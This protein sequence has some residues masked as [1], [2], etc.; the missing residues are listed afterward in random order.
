MIRGKAARPQ[1]AT[2]HAILQRTFAFVREE[3]LLLS[4]AGLTA[5]LRIPSLFEPLW[6]GDEA[7]YLTVGQ[8]LLR[9]DL[10]YV[11]IFDNKPPALYY[12]TAGSL[13]LFGHSVAAIKALP[14]IASIGTLFAFYYVARRLLD[15]PAALLGAA[16][17]SFLITPTWL[18]GNIVG[19]EILMILPTCIGML[20]GLQRRYFLAGCSFGL[21]F[22]FKVPAIFDFGAF[23]VFVALSVQKGSERRTL[24][25]LGLLATGL[26]TPF[27]LTVVY[28][29]AVG[30]LDEYFDS[31]FLSGVD[32]TSSE[33]ASSGGDFLFS[34]G[35][36]I[37]NG[38]PALLLVTVLAGRTFRRWPAGQPAAP[39]S[40][41][42]M[43]LWLAFSFYGVLLGGRPY[44]HYL[45]QAAPPFALLVA[46]V[47]TRSE[48]RRFLSAGALLIALAVTL[49]Q[50]FRVITL[51]QDFSLRQ[52]STLD[53]YID[54]N[55]NFVDYVFGDKEFDEYANYLDGHTAENYRVA[56]F[57]R[58]GSRGAEESLY[59]LSN[60]AAIYFQSRFYP[61]TRYVVFYHLEWDQARMEEAA[62]D[63]AEAPPLYLTA[64][65]PPAADFP[66]LEEI[67]RKDYRLVWSEGKLRLY[68]RR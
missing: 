40:F 1:R 20:L 43:L 5:L 51:D 39:D 21:A 4:I 23:F 54:Y 9:G 56:S 16:I 18:E 31:A 63:L 41:E 26:L 38:L 7:V 8:Q 68:K 55:R 67:I 14:L 12:L 24:S 10:L 46:F 27:A 47:V 66:A 59:V 58:E 44:E 37:V 30:G 49:D 42:F 11:D 65:E 15:K 28:F 13:A 35:R 48:R 64:E 3:W 34:H 36:L 60:Q 29:A 6:Y 25:D 53:Y 32:Y 61:A 33:E 19:S 45:I 62:G 50:D 22:L 57:M 2:E 17:L 52:R